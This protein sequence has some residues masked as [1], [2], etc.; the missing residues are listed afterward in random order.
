MSQFVPILLLIC[1][2]VIGIIMSI[3]FNCCIHQ[4]IRSRIGISPIIIPVVEARQ[5]SGEIPVNTVI[6]EVN[7]DV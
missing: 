6:I 5:I 1:G 4:E 2:S 7:S 3:W